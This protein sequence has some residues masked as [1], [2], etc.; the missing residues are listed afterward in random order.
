MVAD[1]LLGTEILKNYPDAGTFYEDVAVLQDLLFDI[2]YEVELPLFMT[3]EFDT[4]TWLGT[5]T[6]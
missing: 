5:I 2:H 6:A 3:Y 1:D 4:G